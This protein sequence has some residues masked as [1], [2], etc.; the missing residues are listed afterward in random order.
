MEQ[1]VKMVLNEISEDPL[2]LNVLLTGKRVQLA[3]DLSKHY[4]LV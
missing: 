2:L 1:Q 3:E 4:L